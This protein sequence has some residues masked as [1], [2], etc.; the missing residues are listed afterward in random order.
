MPIGNAIRWCYMCQRQLDV[1][2]CEELYHC[3]ICSRMT[4]RYEDIMIGELVD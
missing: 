3:P 2:E 4:G 1:D